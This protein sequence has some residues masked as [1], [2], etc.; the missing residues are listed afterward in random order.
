MA[1]AQRSSAPEAMQ[2]A[3]SGNSSGI[4][5]DANQSRWT[6]F[7]DPAIFGFLLLFAI[8]LPHS[9]KGA[10]RS[11]K[12]A[13]VLWLLKLAIQGARPYRQPLAAPLLAYVTLSAISTMLSPDPYLSWDRMKLVCL[14]LIAIL[15]GE[16][17]KRLSQVRILVL[18]LVASGFAAAGFTAWQYTYGVGVQVK[19][20]R[21]STPLAKTNIR[22]DDVITK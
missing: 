16:N 17:L 5:L 7:L 8:T 21:P 18:L 22:I 11:W 15:F 14:V 10:E 4:N 13:F 2:S 1:T 19:Q 20:M 3:V 9:I 6:R 12:I